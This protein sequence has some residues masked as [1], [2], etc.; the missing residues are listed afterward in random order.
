MSGLDFKRQLAEAKINIPI[1][2]IIIAL[3]VTSR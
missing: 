2:F 1:V 3:T